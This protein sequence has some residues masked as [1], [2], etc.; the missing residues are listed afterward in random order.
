MF[1]TI[2]DSLGCLPTKR[3]LRSDMLNS[4]PIYWSN[5]VTYGEM[6][7]P[8]CAND[9]VKEEESRIIDVENAVFDLGVMDSL[10]FLFIDQ[11]V[12]IGMITKFIKFIELNFSVIT[13]GFDIKVCM[14]KGPQNPPELSWISILL[15][16]RYWKETEWSRIYYAFGQEQDMARKFIE[17]IHYGK[18][19][20]RRRINGRTEKFIHD[21]FHGFTQFISWKDCI[22]HLWYVPVG[23]QLGSESQP[24]NPSSD[25]TIFGLFFQASDP[26]N[27]TG[28]W[29]TQGK[30]S[31]HSEFIR[32]RR[33]T[34][35]GGIDSR[36]QETEFIDSLLEKSLLEG[37]ERWRSE[38]R[39]HGLDCRVHHV[40][41]G[42]LLQR[43][44][45]LL[46]DVTSLRKV[47]LKVLPLGGYQV[48]VE[49]GL[50]PSVAVHATLDETAGVEELVLTLENI[51]PCY[52]V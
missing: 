11:R 35:L 16:Q 40:L 24:E 22:Q 46:K 45:T 27:G 14:L 32:C 34:H 10:C 7:L 20:L 39:R 47:V 12:F 36:V 43:R 44:G 30:Q 26:L 51:W 2:Y 25:S 18:Q 50:Q 5:G 1:Y 49:F 29:V 4:S 42:H 21:D 48:K 6:G 8:I 23:C 13:R 52:R 28:K 38:N 3:L 33:Q 31:S 19:K 15:R 9:R 37:S 41:L 17:S